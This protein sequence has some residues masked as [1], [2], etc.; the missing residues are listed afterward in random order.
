MIN[1]RNQDLSDEKKDSDRSSNT[2]ARPPS[3][4]K[5][6]KT[7]EFST[8]RKKKF[9]I[10]KFS[11]PEFRNMLKPVPKLRFTFGGYDSSN[12]KPNLEYDKLQLE[13]YNSQSNLQKKSSNNSSEGS[14]FETEKCNLSLNQK[15]TRLQELKSMYCFLKVL[16]IIYI[17]SGI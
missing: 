1:L 11:S 9:L 6:N 10:R 13:P 5:Q 2:I 15:F 17:I 7:R 3:L 4:Y 16:N 14:L 8:S 12:N